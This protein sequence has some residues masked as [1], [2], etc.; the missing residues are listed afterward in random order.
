M[1]EGL[2]LSYRPMLEPP[3]SPGAGESLQGLQEAPGHGGCARRLGGE[4][5][6]TTTAVV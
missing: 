1:A 4:R 6:K 5:P 3:D 2:R